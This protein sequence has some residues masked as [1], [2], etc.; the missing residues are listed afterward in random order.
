[1]ELFKMTQYFGECL[2]H[3]AL[4]EDQ[5]SSQNRQSDTSGII[6]QNYHRKE[7]FVRIRSVKFVLISHQSL[8]LLAALIVI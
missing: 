6:H 2:L 3:A 5:A 8:I 1:M 7:R 4:Q